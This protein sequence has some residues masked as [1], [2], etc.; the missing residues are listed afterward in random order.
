ML[1]VIFLVMSHYFHDTKDYLVTQ[2]GKQMRS[3]NFL[4]YIIAGFAIF[5][6][7][8]PMMIADISARIYQV[9]YFSIHDIPKIKRSDYVVLDRWKMK[10]LTLRQKINC[11][12]CEYANGVAN[13]LKALV[14]QTEI[15]SC[16]IK[17]QVVP[18]GQEKQQEAYYERGEWEK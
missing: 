17:H 8:I 10:G 16:A 2:E 12:Y 11:W 1:F 15:Y 3:T 9:V 18:K 5:G 6:M 14:T 13:W 4:G 7:A